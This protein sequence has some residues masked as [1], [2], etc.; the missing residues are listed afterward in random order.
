[1][2]LSNCAVDLHEFFVVQLTGQG[3]AISELPGVLGQY[4]EYALRNILGGVCLVD[5][6]ERGR[7]NQIKIAV[8]DGCKCS[9]VFVI[10]ISA[11]QLLVGLIV[12][13]EESTRSR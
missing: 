5:H 2:I 8:Y 13:S 7:I 12:H 10:G 4:D 6:A 1:M 9:F 11:Q 3:R